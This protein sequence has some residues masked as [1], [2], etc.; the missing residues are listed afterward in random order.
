KLV[1]IASVAFTSFNFKETNRL[2]ARSTSLKT[3]VLWMF[4][5]SDRSNA[6]QSRGSRANRSVNCDTESRLQRSRSGKKRPEMCCI[7]CD[8]FKTVLLTGFQQKDS[9]KDVEYCSF[10]M[11]FGSL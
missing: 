3:S 6:D 10:L 4:G 2:P 7:R 1:R 11:V 5:Y 9:W 8:T